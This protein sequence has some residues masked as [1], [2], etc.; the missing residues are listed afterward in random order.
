M[1]CRFQIR[2]EGRKD[3]SLGVEVV[4]RGLSLAPWLY[5]SELTSEFGETL[6]KGQDNISSKMK[7]RYDWYATKEFK[8]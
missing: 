8:N 3:K 2:V 1:F 5:L 6:Y 4:Q 7:L